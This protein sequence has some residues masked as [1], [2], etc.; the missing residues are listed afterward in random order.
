DK[1]SHIDYLKVK[2]V[3]LSY[4]LEDSK[5]ILLQDIEFSLDRGDWVALVG[6]NGVGKST[7]LKALLHEL[8]PD[9]GVITWGNGV[10]IGYSDQE[11]ET[12]HPNNT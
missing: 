10:T 6:P 2:D 9:R 8:S 5:K 7:L 12:L 3:V 4:Q 11:Q 1:R